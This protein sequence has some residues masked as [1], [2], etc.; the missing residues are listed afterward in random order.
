M[1][2]VH[3]SRLTS[4]A[5]TCAELNFMIVGNYEAI[6]DAPTYLPRHIR[7]NRKLIPLVDTT[8]REMSRERAVLYTRMA[9]CSEQRN[10]L[11]ADHQTNTDIPKQ[12]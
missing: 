10:V 2:M 1:S 9:S 6:N 5:E 8:E 3:E 12:K 11:F 4:H 7:L